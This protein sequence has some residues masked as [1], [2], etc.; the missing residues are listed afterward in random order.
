MTKLKLPDPVKKALA[1]FDVLEDEL[2]AVINE[3]ESKDG[4]LEGAG[5]A[6]KKYVIEKIAPHLGLEA[7]MAIGANI[8]AQVLGNKPGFDPDH[9]NDA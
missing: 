6:A 2:L 5:E 3:A 9:G 7:A 4:S 1:A 8:E